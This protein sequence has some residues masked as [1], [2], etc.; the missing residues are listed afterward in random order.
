MQTPRI[1]LPELKAQTGSSRVARIH[2]L[3]TAI[4]LAAGTMHASPRS[5]FTIS[6]PS[7]ASSSQFE[8]K[9]GRYS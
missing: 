4:Y 1:R 9:N 7:S 5:I 2:A 8:G 3:A 6:Q